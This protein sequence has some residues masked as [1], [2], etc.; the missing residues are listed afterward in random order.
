M[1]TEALWLAAPRCAWHRSA[2]L[3]EARDNL[4]KPAATAA[5][6]GKILQLSGFPHWFRLAAS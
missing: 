6:F 4:P 3:T 5:K 1:M 2:P